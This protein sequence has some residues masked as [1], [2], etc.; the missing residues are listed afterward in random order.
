MSMNKIDKS[1]KQK[2]IIFC[3]P[4]ASGKTNLAH[5]YAKRN[6]GEI[7]NADSM[8]IYKQIPIITASPSDALKSELPY[9][10]YNFRD[11]DNEIS[12]ALY[13]NLAA[14]KV[15]EILQRDRLPVI[16]GGS[17]MYI[18]ML[19]NGYSPIP[20][21]S[22]NNRNKARAEYA[23]MG[24]ELFYLN[25]QKLDPEITNIFKMQDKQ[26]L[27]RAYEV[28]LETGKSI[29]QFQRAENILPLPLVEF[30]IFCMHP[31]R[32]FLYNN[33]N[34]RFVEL[35][36]NGAESEAVYVQKQYPNLNTSAMKALGLA[37]II[38]YLKGKINK[39]TAIELASTKTRQYAKRQ[40]TWFS[41][42]VPSKELLEYSSIDEFQQIIK[43]VINNE[44]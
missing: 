22:Q 37:E 4:T 5:E 36:E 10:L 18:N 12:A 42:Q 40:V 21:I 31:E 23:E 11:V 34:E 38:D 7:I 25:L 2:A 33:C 35:L 30:Q 20:D 24:S 29:L 14:A 27:M 3:G 6:G 41:N 9:H 39:K 32:Q 8:Q 15:K 44:N 43:K 13:V 28:L 19:V 1:T 26:R 17:G 16:V